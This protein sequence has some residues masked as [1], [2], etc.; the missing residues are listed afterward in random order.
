MELQV[1]V[2]ILLKNSEGEYLLL[3]RAAGKY[4][5]VKDGWDIPG[6]RINV[7]YDLF[8]NLKRE[9]MEETGLILADEPQL[10]AAQDIMKPDKHVVRMTYVGETVGG[11]VILSGEH[12]VFQ[13]FSVANLRN[14]EGCDKYLAEL[15]EKNLIQ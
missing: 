15:L 6:G 1:G 8:E 10:V 4:P 12:D 7:D 2:K 13:W 14:L 9:V 11:E 3:R 5:D